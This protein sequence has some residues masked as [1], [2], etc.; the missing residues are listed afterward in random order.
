MDQQAHIAILWHMHQP[1]YRDPGTGQLAMPWVRLH[2]LRGYLDML[3]VCERACEGARAVF[4]F[5]PSLLVQMEGY[6]DGSLTDRYLEIS[7][8]PVSELSPDERT[9][10]VTNFFHA[11]SRTM[12]DCFPR[13]RQ[14]RMLSRLPGG[15]PRQMKDAD[16]HDLVVWFNLAWMGY[17]A[18]REYPLVDELIRQGTR[19]SEKQKQDLLDLHLTIMRRI[20]P[21]YRKALERG[22]IEITATPF[23][24]PILPLLCDTDVA[25]E[26]LP[27]RALPKPPFSA[28]EDA[29]THVARALDYHERTFG[30][31]PTGMWPAEGSVSP[32]AVG[33]FARNGV[34]WVAT[35]QDILSRSLPKATR[36]DLFRPYA[37]GEPGAQVSIVFRERELADSIGFRYASM[38]AERAVS[39]FMTR[40][41]AIRKECPKQKTPPLI[42]II[43]DGENAWEYY[44]DSGEGFLTAMYREVEESP[45]FTWTTVSD[46]LAEYPPTAAIPSIFPGSWIGGNFDIWI[47]SEEENAGWAVLRN[48]R[49]ALEQRGD[50]L[51]ANTRH[52]AWEQL[53]AAEGSDWFWWYGDDFTTSLQP[54]FD[55]LFRA[56]VARVY[57][58]IGATTPPE[59][60]RPIKRG[61]EAVGRRPTA[62]ITPT[63]DGRVT[64]YY[65]WVEAG[66]LDTSKA[67]SSMARGERLIASIHYGADHRNLYLRVDPVKPE[68]DGAARKIRIRWEFVSHPGTAV[69]IAP[70]AEKGASAELRLAN[71]RRPVPVPCATEN[72]IECAL[73][74]MAAGFAPGTQCEFVVAADEDGNEVERW[75]RDGLLAVE[76]PSETY[77]LDH[78]SA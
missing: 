10:V 77:E 9:F 34:E 38:P 27:G 22:R 47:G 68:D 71:S 4:N 48:A 67:D 23:Y 6:L 64:N 65:E 37:T 5:V 70:F 31:R 58:L 28:P 63:L 42:T 57:H 51:A 33:I 45:D 46:H 19:F 17:T 55:R 11:N 24:H 40:L 69:W 1:D 62:L 74:L 30:R 56:H 8:K 29:N 21:D 54:E 35:D 7:R 72:V 2:S 66:E 12:I 39:D 53:Y 49:R 18:R 20:V 32:E 13:Y 36:A 59:V 52:E 73:P 76:A 3:H 78:W 15:A 41:R 44:P 25:A 60:L 61:R 43:L 14:L 26:G 16:L 75:P 50:E